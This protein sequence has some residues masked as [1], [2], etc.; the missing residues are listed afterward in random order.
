MDNGLD[1]LVSVVDHLGKDEYGDDPG[2]RSLKYAVLH[3]QAAAEV[4]L[5][6]RLEREHWSL[7]AEK[8][9][10]KKLSRVKFEQGDFFSIAPSEAVRRLRDI[11]GFDVST[12][13]ASNLDTLTK[14]RNALQ[15]YGLT[16]NYE[17]VESLTAKVLDFLIR[18]L[19]DSLLPE[20]G[21]EEL[22]AVTQDVDYVRAGANRLRA[23]A[24]ERLERIRPLLVGLEERTVLCPRCFQDAVVVEADWGADP[25]VVPRCRFCATDWLPFALAAEYRIVHNAGLFSDNVPT[26]HRCGQVRTVVRHVTRVSDLRQ[27]SSE[28]PHPLHESVTF[29]FECAAPVTDQGGEEPD[30]SVSSKDDA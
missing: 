24:D 19:D 1:Y 27:P 7:V 11:V 4:L 21:S 6:A 29:C 28:D 9:T 8:I 23:Y 30:D 17:V 12:E 5:K 10:D 22:D 18:F 16:V 20:L 25:K 26:C 15:H 2:P 14:T 13:E 3:L